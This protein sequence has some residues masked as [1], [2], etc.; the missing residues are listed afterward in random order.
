MLS[1]FKPMAAG[2]EAY[3]LRQNTLLLAVEGRGRKRLAL[4]LTDL[5]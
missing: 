4:N 1:A 2:F 5:S 3:A